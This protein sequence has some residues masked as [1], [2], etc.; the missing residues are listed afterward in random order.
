VEVESEQEQ[1][2]HGASGCEL[3]EAATERFDWRQEDVGRGGFS[4]RRRDH[5]SVWKQ[6]DPAGAS[7]SG[8]KNDN[9]GLLRRRGPYAHGLS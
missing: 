8:S 2:Q 9:A 4:L 3:P 6:K 1:E 7:E 5:R